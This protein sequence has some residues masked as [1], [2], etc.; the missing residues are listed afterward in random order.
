L[1]YGHHFNMPMF[2][3]KNVVQSSQVLSSVFLGQTSMQAWRHRV[4]LSWGIFRQRLMSPRRRRKEGKKEGRRYAFYWQNEKEARKKGGDRFKKADRED[5]TL[6]PN[7]FSRHMTPIKD[8]L[9]VMHGFTF[10]SGICSAQKY[11]E[12]EWNCPPRN[13][14][15]R[16]ADFL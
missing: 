9:G 16:K 2:V 15:V 5:L 10:S 13:P 7:F 11:R 8:K 4:S 1:R 14:G 3:S 12:E 6:I